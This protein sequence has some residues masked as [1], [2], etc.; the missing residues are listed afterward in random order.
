MKAIPYLSF[1]GNCEEAITYYHSVLGGKLE[2]LRYKDLPSGEGIPPSENWKEKVMHG[3]ILFDDGNY[4]FFSDAWEE[5]PITMGTNSAVHLQ[6]ETE[7]DVYRIVEKLSVGGTISM[8]A[9][10][11]FW[12]A[13]Y[14]SFTDRFGVSWGV[15]YEIKGN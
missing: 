12:N 9:E 14:G 5:S 2:I 4:L 3:S 1:N 7:K 11:T 8:P 6:V 13:V 15:E 10:K